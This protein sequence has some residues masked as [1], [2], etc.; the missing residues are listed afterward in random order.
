MDVVDLLMQRSSLADEQY[1]ELLRS[2][3]PSL[4]NKLFAAAQ[5]AVNYLFHRRVYMQGVLEFTN[6][7]PRNCFYCDLREENR[8]KKRFRLNSEEIR[9]ALK[10]GY[11]LGLRSFILES[12]EDHY[13]T[14]IIMGNLISTLKGEFPDCA[15]GLSIGERSRL[16]YSRMKKSGADR[17]LLR[18]ETADPLHFSR[19]HPPSNSLSTKIDCLNDLKLLGYELD[20]GFLV[21]APYEMAEYLARDLTM[22][23]EINPDT[24]SLS[25]FVPREG[26]SFRH[27]LPCNLETFLRLTAILRVMFP[28]ANI[29]ASPLVNSIHVQG[30]VMAIYS[31]ANVLRVP[32]FPPPV[33]GVTRRSGGVFLLRRLQSLYASLSSHNYEMVVDRG[34]SLRF[35]ERHP[36]AP[37]Q[38]N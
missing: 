15:L 3:D 12:G 26:T 23:Q 1:L 4:R 16:S 33:P 25:P 6:H 28:K 29:A 22:L 7:C 35:L 21:G 38:K 30:Q 19:L 27:Q 36:K 34:D 11:E 2:Q 5:E 20:T 13:Y 9:G 8:D 32:L 18:F 17:Y 24:I 14:D 10:E 37:A 31:G